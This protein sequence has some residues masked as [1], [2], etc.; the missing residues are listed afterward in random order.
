M[1]PGA[2]SV[3]SSR[4]HDYISRDCVPLSYNFDVLCANDL[5]MCSVDVDSVDLYCGI[6]DNP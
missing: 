4:L 5:D 6:F 1:A 2:V 3:A